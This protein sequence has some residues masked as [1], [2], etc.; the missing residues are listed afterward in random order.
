MIYEYKL[1]LQSHAMYA[2]LEGENLDETDQQLQL[3]YQFHG[4]FFTVTRA[5]S[6]NRFEQLQDEA[7]EIESNLLVLLQHNDFEMFFAELEKFKE[8]HAILV[9]QEHKLVKVYPTLDPTFKY[10]R[11]YY[12][13]QKQQSDNIRT[14]KLA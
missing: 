5:F 8:K 6:R 11:K 14:E 4:R 13:L 12:V 2:V 3:K 10:E 9:D 1:H 7:K